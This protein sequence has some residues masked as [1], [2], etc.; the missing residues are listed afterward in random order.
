[1][2]RLRLLIIVIGV[3]WSG[4]TCAQDEVG[5]DGASIHPGM[6]IVEPTNVLTAT[7]DKQE[8]RLQPYRERRPRW[9]VA[10]GVDYSTYTPASYQPDFVTLPFDQVYH[11]ASMPMV[12][13]TF[14]VKRNLDWGSLGGEVSVGVYQSDSFDPNVVDSTLHLYPV[15]LGGIFFLDMIAPEPYVVP[16]ISGGAYTMIFKEQTTGTSKNGNTQVAPYVNGGV[17]LQLD[18]IDR[19]A[20]RVAYEDSGIESSYLT[21]EVR[22][23][24]K[25]SAEKDPDFSDSVTFAAGVRVEF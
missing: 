22:K 11:S 12:D 6:V 4:L 3:F 5:E 25:S 14:V 10:V 19:K 9:G 16:Y 18:W 20:A 13:L 7:A 1:M 8:Y 24:M 2:H 15:H 17:Q 21:L 23:L